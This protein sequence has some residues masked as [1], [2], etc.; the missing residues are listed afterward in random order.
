MAYAG[1]LLNP[2]RRSL[3]VITTSPQSLSPA[4]KLC[5]VYSKF[6]SL[7]PWRKNMGPLLRTNLSRVP[8]KL[9]LPRKHI[10]NFSLSG[11]KAVGSIFGVSVI[12]GSI[13]F[14]PDVAYAMD[15]Q[16]VL[17]DDYQI[18]LVGASAP[19][20][21]SLAFWMFVRKFWLPAFFLLTVLVNWDHP[22]LL[23]TKIIALLFSSK[24]SPLSVYLYVEQLCHQFMREKPHLYIFKT[25]YANKVEVQ[26]YMLLCLARVE[27]RN[28]KLTLIGIL[29][30]W[31][32]LPSSQRVFSSLRTLLRIKNHV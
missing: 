18:D 7:K 24:P 32:E 31:W 2:I 21:D 30:G 29:G 25:L 11:N 4:R 15:G 20:R 23:V 14:Q 27:V 8:Y 22:I 10:Q 26:D 13:C 6:E 3:T 16:D 9:I 1:I 12:F 28:Q 19:E 17:L 5:T